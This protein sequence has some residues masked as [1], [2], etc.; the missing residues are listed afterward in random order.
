MAGINAEVVEVGRQ[1][2]S[3]IITRPEHEDVNKVDEI[4]LRNAALQ[5]HLKRTGKRRLERKSQSPTHFDA[6]RMA[7]TDK[8]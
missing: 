3:K 1:K 6:I 2:T 5:D 7:V 4:M 8:M